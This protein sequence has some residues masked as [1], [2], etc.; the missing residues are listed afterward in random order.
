M[1]AFSVSK[2][3][4][5]LLCSFLFLAQSAHT[6]SAITVNKVKINRLDKQK[7]KQGDWIFFDRQG[8]IQLS[9]RYENN[10]ISGPVCWYENTDTAF[11]RFPR[12]ENRETFIV[13][14][15]SRSYTGDFIYTSDSTY[16][17]ELDPDSTISPAVISKIKKYWNSRVAPVYYFAQK[18]LVDVVSMGFNSI[19]YNFNKPVYLLVCIND[20]GLVTDIEF[21]KDINRLTPEEERELYTAFISMPRW[22]P[23]FYR[24]KTI[25]SKILVTRNSSISVSAS[26]F[27]FP[28]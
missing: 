1:N 7:R 28:L 21:P 19:K 9:C 3:Y 25:A 5:L 22:Q 10:Q 17:I 8:N 4:V 26:D 13:Y 18:K 6:Q 2:L 24:N 16:Q 11:I 27:K 15:N 12:T 14:E 20:A 23:A